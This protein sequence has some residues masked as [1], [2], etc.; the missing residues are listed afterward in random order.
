MQKGKASKL[1]AGLAAA[2]I[3]TGRRARG[4]RGAPTKYEPDVAMV[5]TLETVRGGFYRI[6]EGGYQVPDTYIYIC[7]CL[8]LYV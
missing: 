1:V 2:S 8:Y 3:A 7:I 6:S 5:K 4:R